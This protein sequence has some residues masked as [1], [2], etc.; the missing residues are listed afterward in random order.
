LG[1]VFHVYDRLRLSAAPRRYT[2]EA[3]KAL[4]GEWL[5][6]GKDRAYDPG[7]SVRAVSTGPSSDAAGTNRKWRGRLRAIACA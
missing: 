2:V 4:E 3:G 7:C 6:Q 5:L 1:A